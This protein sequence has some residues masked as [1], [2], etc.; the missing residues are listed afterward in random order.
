MTLVACSYLSIGCFYGWLWVKLLA[1]DATAKRNS[2]SWLVLWLAATLWIFIVPAA[3]AVL[4][5]EKI[6]E[7]VE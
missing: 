3:Y 1:Q 5:R 7:A 4:L 6:A 2:F